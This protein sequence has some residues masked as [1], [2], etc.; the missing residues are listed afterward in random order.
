MVCLLSLWLLAGAATDWF[1]HGGVAPA[2][3]LLIGHQ[4]S[5]KG[6]VHQS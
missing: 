4:R 3:L 1:R 2:P 5:A 6:D